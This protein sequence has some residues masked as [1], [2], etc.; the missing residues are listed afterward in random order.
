MSSSEYLRSNP[1]AE[2]NSGIALSSKEV[3][4]TGGSSGNMYPGQGGR[5]FVQGGGGMSQFHSFDGGNVDSMYARGSYAPVTVGHNSVTSGG[6]RRRGRGRGRGRSSS[7]RKFMR[8]GKK[9]RCILF[10]G[11]R[12]RRH[13]RKCHVKNCHCICHSKSHSRSRS[14]S[15]TRR[16]K[17]SGGN[18]N[19]GGSGFANAAYSIAGPGTGIDKYSSALAS[20][21]PHSAY[22]SCHPVV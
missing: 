9:C 19:G 14:R 22:N 15:G 17:Q 3:P 10:G 5:A 4:I 1:L 20:P 11:S 13:S 8:P 16:V 6:S 7:R 12:R 2:H 21:A 18:G